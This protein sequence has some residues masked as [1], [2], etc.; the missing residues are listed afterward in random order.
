MD[1]QHSR[2]RKEASMVF[3]VVDTVGRERRCQ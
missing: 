2:E 3:G 1:S